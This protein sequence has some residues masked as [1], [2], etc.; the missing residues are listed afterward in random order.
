MPAKAGEDLRTGNSIHIRVFAASIVFFIIQVIA[1]MLLSPMILEMIKGSDY[2]RLVLRRYQRRVLHVIRNIERD[3][4]LG[5]RGAYIFGG[6][7]ALEFFPDDERLE[8]LTGFNTRN[9]AT[10]FQFIIDTIRLAGELK[11]RGG[12]VVFTM[13]PFKFADASASQIYNSWYMYGEWSK[14][15]LESDYVDGVLPDD[16]GI[17][18]FMSGHDVPLSLR[19]L[20]PFNALVYLGIDYAKAVRNSMKGEI[21]GFRPSYLYQN[22][23]PL[24]LHDRWY[25]TPMSPGVHETFNR[26]IRERIGKDYEEKM[27]LNFYLLEKLAEIAELNGHAL[28]LLDLPQSR[29]FDEIFPEV[30]ARYNGH[31]S[32]FYRRHPGIRHYR[33]DP[34]RYRYRQENFHDMLHVNPRGREYYEP[35]VAEALNDAISNLKGRDE[36]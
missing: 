35:Y 27:L 23:Y 26:D 15:I 8:E 19:V 14:Y 30:V 11:V 31:L 20:K 4:A 7:S 12:L 3:N 33:V 29:E 5:R 2:D 17:R 34:V 6:S 9:S 32:A 18:K 36:R 13:S 24:T 21:S 28:V 10:G 1:V 16:E 25:D 22:P